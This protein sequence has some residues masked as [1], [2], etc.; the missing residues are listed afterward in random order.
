M[1]RSLDPGTPQSNAATGKA[2]LGEFKYFAFISY[3]HADERWSR[4]L[5][6]ALETYRVPKRLAGHATAHGPI[7]ARL[8]QMF[9]DSQ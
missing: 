6:R 4:W 3:G 8:V 1:L 5:H 7:Q 9:R 2:T